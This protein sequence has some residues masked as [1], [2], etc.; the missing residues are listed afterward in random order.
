MEGPGREWRLWQEALRCLLPSRQHGQAPAQ[1]PASLG[2]EKVVDRG[3]AG[4]GVNEAAR[5]KRG[6]MERVGVPQKPLAS[7]QFPQCALE[8]GPPCEHFCAPE[9]K[10]L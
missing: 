4:R 8:P 7:N 5:N 2:E 9:E 6:R 10:A 3:E 1:T